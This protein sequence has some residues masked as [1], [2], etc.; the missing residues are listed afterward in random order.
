MTNFCLPDIFA[1]RLRPFQM[2]RLVWLKLEDRLIYVSFSLIITKRPK[3]CIC[4]Q[5]LKP[6][7]IDISKR[8][9]Y[10]VTSAIH[11]LLRTF[12]THTNY[13]ISGTCEIATQF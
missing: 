1:N 2:V 10:R 12:P 13:I 3:D 4:F 8:H 9:K 6:F 5:Y 7:E 11:W